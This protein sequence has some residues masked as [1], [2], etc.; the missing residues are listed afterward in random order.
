MIALVKKFFLYLAL[1]VMGVAGFIFLNVYFPDASMTIRD[2]YNRISQYTSADPVDQAAEIVK[3][4]LVSPSSFHKVTGQVIWKGTNSAGMPA[5]VVS[6]LF[7]GANALGASLRGCMFVSYSET[8]EKKVTW[9]RNYGVKD[10][11]EIRGLCEESTPMEMK[12]KM[13][14][15]L[16]EINFKTK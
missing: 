5:Y 11:S 9:D 13:V 4:Q 12:R 3:T 2:V 16:V 1:V 15:T 8:K 10:F 6:V 7:D 14:D